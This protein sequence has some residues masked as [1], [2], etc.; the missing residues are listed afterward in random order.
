MLTLLRKVAET[1]TDTSQTYSYIWYA[2]KKFVSSVTWK[3]N[4]YKGSQGS[5]VI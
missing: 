4:A 5:V 3:M 1:I 2:E